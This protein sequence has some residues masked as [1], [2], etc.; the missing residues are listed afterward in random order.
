MR[1]LYFLIEELDTA[2]AMAQT[3]KSLNIDADGYYIVSRDRDG[4]RRHHLHDV[5]VINETDL[6]HTGERGVLMGGICG[7]LFALWIAVM[8]PLG[9]FMTLW[10]F[11][12][13]SVLIGCFGAWVGG[14]VGISHENYKLMPFHD[15]I[16]QGKYLMVISVRE[17]AKAREVR[18]V[19][20]R[21]HPDALFEAEDAIG[22]DVLAD[23]AEF[24]SRHL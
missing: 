19:M 9:L 11:L 13:V 22:V 21:R 2:E 5:S 18:Q 15:A 6:I 1:T 3:L 8:K 7:L 12:F 24:R 20:H 17:V 4:L 23:K 16:A 14:M 10:S